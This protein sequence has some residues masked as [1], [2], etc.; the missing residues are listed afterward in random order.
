MPSYA[1]KQNHWCWFQGHSEETARFQDQFCLLSDVGAFS[2]DPRLYIP[3]VHHCFQILYAECSW[4]SCAWAIFRGFAAGIT[5]ILFNSRR[6][7][8][9]LASQEAMI[10]HPFSSSLIQ[11]ECCWESCACSIEAYALVLLLQG[12]GILINSGKGCKGYCKQAYSMGKEVL[13]S[14][15]LWECHVMPI[16]RPYI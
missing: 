3:L 4:E 2:F 8:Q 7:C 1:G 6:G 9:Q 12:V 16:C 5:G 14:E 11:I 13:Y 10:I 15:E